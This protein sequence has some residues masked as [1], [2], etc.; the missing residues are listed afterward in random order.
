MTR[1]DAAWIPSELG[2]AAVG[3]GAAGESALS[4][5]KVDQSR[6]AWDQVIDWKL[7]D[8]SSD[9]DQLA[10]DGILP[11]SP[12][13][14]AQA[15]RIARLMR[16]RHCAP[17]TSVVPSGDRGIVFERARGQVFEAIEIED[18]GAVEYRLFEDC[19]LVHRQTLA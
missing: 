13:S 9:P 10:D 6:V 2:L 17:P 15:S 19:R 4:S 7:K 12:E 14:I 18:D 1:L 5:D 11:P 3:A 16:D 8:W